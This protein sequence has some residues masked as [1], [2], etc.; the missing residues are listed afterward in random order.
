MVR[1]ARVDVENFRGIS[2]ASVVLTD[3]TV[4]LGD[5]NTGKSA[6]LE[7][8]E[9]TIGPDRLYR[10]P[11]ISEHDF[12]GGRY[13]D[14]EVTVIVTIAGLTPE[15][16]SRFRSHVEYWDAGKEIAME[17]PPSSPGG[18]ACIRIKFVGR[19]DKDEDDFVGDTWFLVPAAPD[20]Q[21]LA[22]CTATDKRAFGFLLL[23][24]LRT[25]SRA[26]SMERGSL[27]DVVLRTYEVEVQ[28]WEQLLDRL[29]AI[30]VAS[31]LPVASA[32]EVTDSGDVDK[33]GEVL[34]TLE[35]TLRDIVSSEWAGTPHLRVSDLTREELRRTLRAF[36]TTGASSHAAPFQR[37]GSGT[38][39]SLVIAMLTMIAQRREGTVIFAVEEPEISLP[40]TAQK[41]IVDLI[42]EITKGGQSVFTSH[43]PYILEEFEPE[44]MMV[45][46]RDHASGAMTGRAVELPSGLKRKFFHEGMR[47]RFAEALLS[48]RVIVS[49]GKSE[50]AG[51][52]ALG[53]RARLL[54]ASDMG[55]LDSDGWAF[56]DAES[57]TNVARLAEFF[58]GL[59]KQ[60][61]TVFDKQDSAV[62][63]Q[64]NAASD[65]T[66]EQQYKGFE[67]LL[68]SE[69]PEQ[70][71]RAFVD[72]QIADALWPAHVKGPLDESTLE[73]DKA[74]H[75]LLVKAKGD[76][77]AVE[78]L[79]TLSLAE[80]P[81]TMAAALRDLRALARSP[82]PRAEGAGVSTAEPSSADEE[83]P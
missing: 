49:E 15:L 53:K 56:L 22:R 79:A 69:I 24:T 78:L 12:Y 16:I 20:G 77:V 13:L 6:L 30:D 64:I 62:L 28:M 68:I 5:N 50:I 74:L 48:R 37:Q 58:K 60:V 41:R 40:P 66:I 42:R 39:N 83:T 8:I 17:M 63:E 61:A 45:L 71:R 36:V 54:G 38:I 81:M 25:G 32:G 46:S 43:S 65:L 73:Y 33:F 72:Q 2:R 44:Q 59:G 11:P 27:L 18:E 57:E 1:V 21:S 10:R 26:L 67:D 14:T 52:S 7:A 34:A 80:F 70:R 35:S 29:R 23:R 55:R 9:L 4:L 76:P 82:L 75:R 3:T 31:A 19:Y 51:Y 47:T